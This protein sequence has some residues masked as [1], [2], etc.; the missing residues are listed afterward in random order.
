MVFK[1]EYQINLNFK[2]KNVGFKN[3]YVRIL[4]FIIYSEIKIGLIGFQNENAELRSIHARVQNL[5]V[6][7]ETPNL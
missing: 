1:R 7:R 2:K 3:I 4:E 5:L 6:E